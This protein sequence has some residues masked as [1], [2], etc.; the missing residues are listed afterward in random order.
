MNNKEDA[1]GNNLSLMAMGSKGGEV[2]TRIRCRW[3][4]LGTIRRV[5][6]VMQM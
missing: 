6:R 2:P 4:G 3:E 1:E 5:S